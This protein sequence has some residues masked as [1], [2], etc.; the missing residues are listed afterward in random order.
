M[1]F[2]WFLLRGKWIISGHEAWARDLLVS[3]L[4]L[5][6]SADGRVY[7][8]AHRPWRTDLIELLSSKIVKKT[9]IDNIFVVDNIRLD[10]IEYARLLIYI[11]PIKTPFITKKLNVIVS[12][13]PTSKVKKYFGWRKAIL[14][15]AGERDFIMSIEGKRIR[16]TLSPDYIGYSSPPQGIYGE[17]LNLLRKGI[18]EYG[19]LSTRDA[20]D[21]ISYNLGIK[22]EQARKILAYLVEKGYITIKK[23][24]V[25]VY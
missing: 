9:I 17:A 20:L 22:R 6:A 11:D 4:S 16:I 23:R 1:R 5:L 13:Y 21:I 2:P 18:V 24:E 3:Y 7:I 14:K 15:R 12:T 8:E 25:L 10:H 19:F